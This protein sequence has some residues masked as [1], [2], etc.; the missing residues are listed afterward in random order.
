MFSL[1]PAAFFALALAKH[2]PQQFDLWCGQSSEHF[3]LPRPEKPMASYGILWRSS[4]KNDRSSWKAYREIQLENDIK[5]WKHSYGN[6]GKLHH[7]CDAGIV[8][9][10]NG[11]EPQT[12][13]RV[14]FWKEAPYAQGSN[15]SL[16]EAFCLAATTG[17]WHGTTRYYTH[18]HA[19]CWKTIQNI[20]KQISKF[21]PGSTTLTWQDQKTS[22]ASSTAQK[23]WELWLEGKVVRCCEPVQCLS[24][25]RRRAN[26]P[27][28]KQS[29]S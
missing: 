12:A 27:M 4:T 24:H 25:H 3:N 10:N 28:P 14:G 8:D 20:S 6:R 15:T 9:N 21:V 29:I 18:L 23:G 19:C 22:G 2:R 1:T 11:E 7:V 16:T 13:K 17:T 26:H 5:W